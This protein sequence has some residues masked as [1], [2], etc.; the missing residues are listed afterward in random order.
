MH[1][2]VCV[3]ARI[4]SLETGVWFYGLS[5]GVLHKISMGL[6]VWDFLLGFRV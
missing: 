3:R 4:L 6:G 5:L 2:F 1:A